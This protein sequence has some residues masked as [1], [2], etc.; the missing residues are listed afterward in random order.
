MFNTRNLTRST[1]L[2][3]YLKIRHTAGVKRAIGG[4]VAAC[5][6]RCRPMWSWSQEV[7]G[8]QGG[9]CAVCR[10]GYLREVI[11]TRRQAHS[12]SGKPVCCRH[13]RKGN[14]ACAPIRPNSATTLKYT[15][16]RNTM[17]YPAMIK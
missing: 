12:L 4:E 13:H 8:N 7:W 14:N 2:C 10:S 15:M 5:D 11:H 16:V 9:N 3:V 6:A 1:K 17:T